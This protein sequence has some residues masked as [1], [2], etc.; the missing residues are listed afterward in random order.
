VPL[1]PLPD[2]T[3]WPAPNTSSC[4]H[5][6]LMKEAVHIARLTI[7]LCLAAGCVDLSHPSALGPIVGNGSGGNGAGGGPGGDAADAPTDRPAADVPVGSN[8]GAG[9]NSPDG[10]AMDSPGS[11]DS[12]SLLPSGRPCAQDNQCLSNVCA[13]GV[14]CNGACADPCRA[15][16]LPGAEGQCLAVPAGEDPKQA[17]AQ[18]LP[19][20]CGQ[21]GTCDGVGACRRYPINAQ[22]APGGCS[23]GSEAAAS[24]C[25]GNG[26]CRP[27]AVTPCS[28]GSCTGGSCGAAC[29]PSVACQ[30]GFFCNLGKCALKA[31]QAAACSADEQCASGFCAGGICCNTRCGEVC[32]ACNITGNAGTCT[33]VPSGQDPHNQCPAQAASTCARAGGCNGSGACRLHAAGVVCGSASCSGLVETPARTCDGLGVCRAAGSPRDCSPYACTT[34]ACAAS[35]TT[36]ASCAPGYSC[37]SNSCVRSPGLALFWRFEEAT[38][39]TALDSSGNGRDGLLL[40]DTGT[41]TPSETTPALKHVNQRSR[42]FTAVNRHAVWIEN[43]P[44]AIKPANDLTVSAWYRA[45]EVDS[46]SGGTLGSEVISGA[47]AY[48]LRLRAYH[49][50]APVK[51][52]EFS[53]R[54][55]NNSFVGVFGVAPNFLDGNWHHIAG[56][57]SKTSG[58]KVY[59]DGVELAALPT[60]LD[61]IVYTTSAKSFFV[62]RHGDGQTQW[63][64][65]GHIDEVRI[66]TRVLSAAE[67]ANL[68]QGLNN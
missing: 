20:T 9:G 37:A 61:D 49:N 46:Y 38:A 8:G 19:A 17:C 62:G 59:F 52:I 35:C 39:S 50:D 27:G 31:A 10:A 41:P 12:T 43:M 22:C 67:I 5:E 2:T 28:S 40:G 24:T 1:T 68:A 60:Q 58:M 47:N 64:F 11:D 18:D 57:A 32:F 14:C 63:D 36:G 45:T 65:S 48:T 55:G 25:D 7:L 34:S 33:P 3:C 42:A 54:I 53:K 23:N 29:G 51:E 66:Y 30:A 56:V 44:A 4:I 21:D 16:N 6:R 13:Q 15:C 26:T